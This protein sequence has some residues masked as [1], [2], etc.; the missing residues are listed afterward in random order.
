MDTRDWRA[1]VH[2]L[3]RVGHD[4]VTKPPDALREKKRKKE[5]CKDIVIYIQRILGFIILDL[6]KCSNYI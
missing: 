2:G 5:N 6:M 3:T 1:T 4:S